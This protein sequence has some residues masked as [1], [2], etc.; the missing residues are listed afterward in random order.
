MGCCGK[1]AAGAIGLARAAAGIGRADVDTVERRR[2]LC[3]DCPEAVPCV[4][5][6][7]K[8]CMCNKC[9]C[10]LKAKTVIASE[11]CPLGKW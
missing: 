2:A 8:F 7:A 9:G 10:L 1:I 3:R 5:N 6:T 4:K 11:K